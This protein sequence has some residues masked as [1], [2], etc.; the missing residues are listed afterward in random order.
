MPKAFTTVSD[1]ALHGNQD[2]HDES[3]ENNEVDAEVLDSDNVGYAMPRGRG[4]YSA[5]GRELARRRRVRDGDGRAA[6]A[7]R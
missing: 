7:C 5:G 2:A 1:H 6:A 3:D 4:R